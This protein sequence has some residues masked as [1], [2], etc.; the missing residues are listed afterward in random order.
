ML[1]YDFVDIG[2]ARVN[3]DGFVHDRPVLSRS[4]VFTYHNQ[5]GT[6]RREWRPPEE[7]FAAPHLASLRGAPITDGHNGIA[8]ADSSH[9]IGT[10]LTEG[11]RESENLSAEIVIHHPGRL[12]TRRE[13]SLGYRL[14]LDD[15]PGTTPDG[16]PYD[17]VQKNLRC[18]HLAVVHRG[19]AGN[20]RLRMDS[21]DAASEPTEA[22]VSTLPPIPPT[23]SATATPKEAT[24]VAEPSV[25]ASAPQA[26]AR[27]VLTRV[28]GIEYQ[29][30]PEV[31]RDLDRLREASKADKVRADTAEAERDALKETA[32][33]FEA[34]KAQVRLDAAAQA[35]ARVRLETE[36]DKHGVEVRS[37][38]SDRDVRE[39]V[40]RKVRGNDTRFDGK[41][42]EY[43]TA[44]YDIAVAE[45]ARSSDQNA[46]NRATVQSPVPASAGARA[47]AASPQL[48]SASAARERMIRNSLAH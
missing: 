18:N 47:D 43:V 22:P 37:D 42:D 13:L 11:Q 27:L 8:R 25:P 17:A 3:D 10:V 4:G 45:A 26:A 24:T 46:R 33:R 7:V 5:D 35:R 15:T 30:P 21:A 12:G 23:L 2:S 48:V 39:A 32:S 9:I 29:A 38:M 28:D 14:D 16:D 1:R 36:A 6:T 20:A 19:R 31:V 44:S 41:S 40:V 34:E